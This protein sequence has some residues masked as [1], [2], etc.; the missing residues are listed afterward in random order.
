MQI[1]GLASVLLRPQTPLT[2]MHHFSRVLSFTALLIWSYQ[3]SAQIDTTQ[4]LAPDSAELDQRIPVFTIS[5]DDL[6]SEME[7]QDISGML[8]SSRDIF[9]STAGYNFGTA[10]FRIR[11]YNTDNT[12]ISLNGVLVNDFETW[13]TTWWKWG[14]LNDVTRNMTVR[15]GI[16]PSVYNFGGLGGF[17]EIDGRAG[18]FRKGTKVSYALSNRSYR[19]RL[20][21]TSSTGMMEN[22]WAFTVSLSRRWADEGYV[23]GTFY[24]AYSYFLSAEKRIND[25]HSFGFIG[26]GAPNKSARNGMATQEA[27]D[28]AGSNYYNPY[29]GYQ[30]GEK[31]NARVR[32]THKPMFMATH[33]FTP[34]RRTNWQ[35]SLYYS[36]GKGSYTSLNWF[37]AK[38]PRP[39]F[40]RYLPSYHKDDPEMFAQVTNDWTNN[41]EVRQIDWDHLYFANRKNLYTQENANGIEGNSVT[42]N[43][44]KYVVEDWRNDLQLYGANTA[45]NTEL[46]DRA[47]LALGGSIHLQSTRNYKMMD[48][49]LG[50]D[51]WVDIDQFALRDFNDEDVAQNDVDNPNRIIKE[52]DVFGYDF[53][54]NVNR[55]NVFGQYNY[56]LTKWELYFGAEISHTSFWRNSDMRNGRFPDD[57]YGKS[58]TESFLHYGVK[59]GAE[60]K[61]SGRHIVNANVMYQ[62]RPPAPKYAYLSPRTRHETLDGLTTEQAFGGD[63][64]YLIRYSKLRVRATGY[65]TQINNQVWARSFWHDELRSFVN[66]S[67]NDVDHLHMGAELGIE[68]DIT[69][70]V[71]VNAVYAGGQ[72]L[73]N[74]R[75]TAKITA[76]NSRE[77]L[78]ENRTV[79]LKNYRIGGMPQTA[80]SI[81][82][83][84]RSPKYWFAGINGNFFGHIYLDPNPDRR[85]EESMGN[86]VT[87]DPQWDQMLDQQRLDDNFTVDL[88][89]GKSWRIAEK[90]F[91]NINLNVSNVLNNQDFVIGGFEQLRYDRTDIDR[92]PPKLSYLFGRSFFAQISFRI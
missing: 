15:T 5:A 36:F 88:F 34:N 69:S 86:Y 26:F 84:Y 42:G 31:R 11:G 81:G 35:T 71:S 68:A 7:S 79:Y 16:Q 41:E 51:F 47:K 14:G 27:Y 48:D 12:L 28:L 4:T 76:D 43:R 92:F 32:D 24:D 44:S 40:Y 70:T 20:M 37:D 30:D 49:L 73:W 90:Y 1:Y 21:A 52:G 82:I 38:D 33:Y 13:R 91:L 46:S 17:S 59:A 39:D 74:S 19:H 66:Y 77:V 18:N 53:T 63:I 75:P 61:I 57:S 62:T 9:T 2:L 85:T 25:K 56:S 54:L 10:R 65:Y 89:V 23:E 3:L 80:A 6:E 8:Q 72:Y 22:N 67:M 87:D 58:A 64:S 55:V 45:F 60:Y 78:A 29:W 50:G 83:K